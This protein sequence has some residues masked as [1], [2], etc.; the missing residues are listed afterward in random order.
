MDEIKDYYPDLIERLSKVNR[1]N[2][3]RVNLSGRYRWSDRY[4]QEKTKKED[5]KK[6]D[7]KQP[8]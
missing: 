5:R 8:S 2:I 1:K 7:E 6:N 4:E 3:V